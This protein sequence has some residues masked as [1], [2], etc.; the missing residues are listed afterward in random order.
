VITIVLWEQK[1]EGAWNKQRE[2]K[3]ENIGGFSLRCRFGRKPENI[4]GFHF[5]NCF[6]HFS[7]EW[8]KRKKRQREKKK[9]WKKTWKYRRIPNWQFF[10]S[11]FFFGLQNTVTMIVL[12]TRKKTWKYRRI[13]FV[14]RVFFFLF[15]RKPENI[16][17][18]QKKTRK[19]NTPTN[20]QEPTRWDFVWIDAT[21]IVELSRG[22]GKA[23]SLKTRQTVTSW[24]HNVGGCFEKSQKKSLVREVSN[25]TGCVLFWLSMFKR[26]ETL[27]KSPTSFC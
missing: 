20:D 9:A 26:M 27:S 18:F 13:P 10:S 25:H 5:G 17:G 7:T 16:G 23:K 19:K 8:K 15:G 3:P 4:G 12:A 14:W 21:R 11:C 24:A 1:G 6:A 2:R 22:F